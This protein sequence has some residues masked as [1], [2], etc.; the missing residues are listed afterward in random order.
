MINEEINFSEYSDS[1]MNDELHGVILAWVEKSGQ[2]SEE[3]ISLEI[4]FD[5]SVIKNAIIKLFKNRLID[6]NKDSFKVSNKGKKIIDTLNVSN[7]IVKYLYVDYNLNKSEESFLNS[8]LH[9]YRNNYYDSYLNTC[10]SVK[11]WSR[12]A[13]SSKHQSKNF[14]F[15][16][17]HTLTIL[18]YD[19]FHKIFNDF[20]NEKSNE[21][22]LK[23]ENFYKS[24]LNSPKKKY[25]SSK[26]FY[27]LDEIKSYEF[28]N[29]DEL[30]SNKREIYKFLC[31]KDLY[32]SDESSYYK[33]NQEIKKP[34]K[35][36]YNSTYF[37]YYSWINHNLS[38]KELG[39]NLIKNLQFSSEK[40][41]ELNNLET[42]VFLLENCENITQLSEQIK[43][44]E[45]SAE[46][47]LVRLNHRIKQLLKNYR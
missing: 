12:I 18:Y 17:E 22:R 47:I 5:Q 44:S 11:V 21:M 14:D 30:D 26:A 7:E 40:D 20:S 29:L 43:V 6:V 46:Q 27:F 23:F 32:L 2:T 38:N 25:K 4:K 10:N 36:L 39:I 3:E 41:R 45:E 24:L 33:F 42:T 37:N 15:D 35:D 16:K 31:F 19:I 9:F 8:S 28:G 13:N 34:S 1:I